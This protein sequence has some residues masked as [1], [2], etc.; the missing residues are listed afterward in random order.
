ME[1]YIFGINVRNAMNRIKYSIRTVVL[2]V[3]IFLLVDLNRK[4]D[5]NA[6]SIVEFKIKTIEKI[7]KDSLGTRHKADLLIDETTRF[8]DHSAHVKKRANNLITL[9]VIFFIV[10]TVF[11]VSKKR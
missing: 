5:D 4:T 8:M 11:L 2:L 3:A 9:L 10:E 1:G 6:Q 7:R